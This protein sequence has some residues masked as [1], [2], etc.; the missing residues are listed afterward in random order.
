M[1]KRTGHSRE[2]QEGLPHSEGNRQEVKKI[3]FCTT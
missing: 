1:G 3:R 2:I